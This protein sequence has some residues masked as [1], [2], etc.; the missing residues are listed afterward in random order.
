MPTVQEYVTLTGS[1]NTIYQKN[2]NTFQGANIKSVFDT[3]P[4]EF[5]VYGLNGNVS[6]WTRDEITL[7]HAALFG[8]DAHFGPHNIIF[9]DHKRRAKTGTMR[10]YGFRLV[11]EKIIN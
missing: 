1:Y 11:A 2:I 4:N 9:S 5:D 8:G 7:N 10:L 3:T 6:E